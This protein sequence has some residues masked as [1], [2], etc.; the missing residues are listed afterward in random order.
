MR[1]I[2]V[3]IA[4]VLGGLFVYWQFTFAGPNINELT[5]G[6]AGRAG[7]ETN[8]T[9]TTLSETVGK[10]LEAVMS[11]VGVIFLALAIYA[12]I[13]WMTAS[14]N[15]EQVTKAQGILKMA[16]IG[17]IIV[18]GAYSITYFVSTLVFGSITTGGGVGGEVDRGILSGFASGFTEAAR[19]AT[20]SDALPIGP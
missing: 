17:L 9:E 20:W 18:I 6:V 2:I 15:D 13:L 7:F 14:G 19:N 10:A 11:F 1:F 3:F 16:T 4:L 12:G 5:P 8:V